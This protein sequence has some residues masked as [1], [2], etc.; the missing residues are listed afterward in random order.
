MGQ[1]IALPRG[2]ADLLLVLV[3]DVHEFGV[4]HVVFTLTAVA[5]AGGRAFATG[6]RRLLATAGLLGGRFVHGLGQF[7]AGGGEA[8]DGA[9]DLGRV[10]LDPTGG[11]R[12]EWG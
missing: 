7:V 5:I 2:L 4:N 1:G 8:V 11:V 6:R 3:V 10:V 9:V 12:R